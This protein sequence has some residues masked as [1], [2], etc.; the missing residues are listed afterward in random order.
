L[1]AIGKE[2]LDTWVS[3]EMK[4]AVERLAL[5]NERSVSSVIRVAIRD[6]VNANKTLDPP[7]VNI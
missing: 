4:R 6:Y 7:H 2:K 3:S 1:S 5:E